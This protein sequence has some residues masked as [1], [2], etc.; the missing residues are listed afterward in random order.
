L[1]FENSIHMGCS[2]LYIRHLCHYT[3]FFLPYIHYY[4]PFCS[5]TSAFSKSIFEQPLRCRARFLAAVVDAR[6]M[7]CRLVLY[8]AG[9]FFDG[10]SVLGGTVCVRPETFRAWPSVAPV[11]HL[12]TDY[13]IYH[14]FIQNEDRGEQDKN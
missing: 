10:R 7:G 4:T 3:S 5:Y 1:L 14:K 12:R 6:L 13:S 9:R 2:I 8:S 11:V